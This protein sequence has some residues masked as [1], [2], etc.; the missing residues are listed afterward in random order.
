[1]RIE[2]AG[3]DEPAR[4]IPLAGQWKYRVA[5]EASREEIPRKPRRTSRPGLGHHDPAALYNGMIAPLE[6]FAIAGVLWYQG[7]TNAG[8]P[9]EYAELLG[10]LI[11][12]WRQNWGQLDS[13][14]FLI[15]QLANFTP[16]AR[17]PNYGG[18]AWIRE[19]QAQTARR[20]PNCGLAVTIDVGQADDVHPRDKQT[21]GR[22]LA[23]QALGRTYGYDIVASGPTCRDH[24]VENGRM[25]LRFGNTGRG[26]VSRA[27]DNK[28]R[29]FVITGDGEN[30]HWAEAKIQDDTVV[31]WSD[32]VAK[33]IAVRY[34]WATN[35]G[36]VD[37]YNSASLPAEPFRTD[38]WEMKRLKP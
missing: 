24:R 3:A 1:M 12:S 27:P 5:F 10:M 26:L 21:V 33:P 23:L 36:P 8:R 6:P 7:E 37:L 28:V 15:V 2:P 18:W 13:F 14:S 29:G 31:V 9:R 32:Q 34:L 22:R 17:V 19:V 16:V 20:V 35:P 38:S 25:I 4:S 30:W 11:R